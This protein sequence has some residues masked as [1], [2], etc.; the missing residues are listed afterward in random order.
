MQNNE[1]IFDKIS[2][3]AEER[4]Y[5][6]YEC[7]KLMYHQDIAFC[8]QRSGNCLLRSIMQMLKNKSNETLLL[9]TPWWSDMQSESM[10]CVNGRRF[11]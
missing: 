3:D 4:N 2:A 6:Y 9:D 7:S 8:L 1:K 5:Y 11:K 10:F